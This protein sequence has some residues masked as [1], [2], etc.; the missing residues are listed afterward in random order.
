MH[1][2]LL[3]CFVFLFTGCEYGAEQVKTFVADPHFAKY[4][5]EQG[6]LESSQLKGK[7]TYAEYL[8]KKQQ[9]E[10]RY[11]QEVKEREAIFHDEKQR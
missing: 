2:V 8:Q 3:A 11:N 10:D 6:A 1:A 9:L 5:E 4:Q 7:I